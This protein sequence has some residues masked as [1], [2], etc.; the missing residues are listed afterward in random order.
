MLTNGACS[1]A[2][3]QEPNCA[4]NYTVVPGDTCD[5]IGAKTN[6]PTSVLCSPRSSSR[7]THVIVGRFQIETVNANKIDAGCDNLFVG[8]VSC[9]V[10]VESCHSC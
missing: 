10:A 9:F 3:A 7:S 4:R 6:T 5:G 8:E 2:F 1:I